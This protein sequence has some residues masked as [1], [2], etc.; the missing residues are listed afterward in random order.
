[1]FRVSAFLIVLSIVAALRAADLPAEIK[2]DLEANAKALSPLTIEWKQQVRPL[3]S[4]EKTADLLRVPKPLPREVVAPRDRK[5][6][7][8]GTKIRSWTDS[9]IWGVREHTF[10]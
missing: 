3:L 6:T 8:H 9:P 4:E 5:L 2:T 7:I 1:M 10:D